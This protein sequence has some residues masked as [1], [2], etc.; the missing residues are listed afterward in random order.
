MNPLEITYGT[1]GRVTLNLDLKVTVELK[2][3]FA[4]VRLGGR[5]AELQSLDL[6]AVYLL[7]NKEMADRIKD[8]LID[9]T[10]H[11]FDQGW[12]VTDVQDVAG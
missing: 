6:G 7:T 12:M 3:T 9:I 11:D 1:D 2:D 4:L 8:I 5:R 10:K